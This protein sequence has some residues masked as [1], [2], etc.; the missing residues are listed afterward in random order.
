MRLRIGLSIALMLMLITGLTHILPAHAAAPT[1]TIWV[2]A[3]DSCRQAI[4]FSQFRL[5]N[6]GET[7]DSGLTAGRI[8]AKD[9]SGVQRHTIAHVNSDCPNQHGDCV[10][11]FEPKYPGYGCTTFTVPLPGVVTTYQFTQI[12]VWP[13]F[14]PCSG[15]SAC[16]G[17][18]GTVT[19]Y[20]DG[21]VAA[22]I[23]NVYPDRTLSYWPKSGSPYSGTAADPIVVHNFQISDGTLPSEWCDAKNI[24][25]VDA[26][27]HL[28]GS[29]S[30]HCENADDGD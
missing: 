8:N 15:G 24:S 3:Q 10:H 30:S 11:I 26:D 14:V 6:A 28:T 13:T 21:H 22:N 23:V 25:Q 16:H 19:V 29:R 9:S 7:I 20:P 4:P 1:I 5:S 17:L 27:D 18:Y 2:Q 12:K